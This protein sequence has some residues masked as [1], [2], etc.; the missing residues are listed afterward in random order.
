MRWSQRTL[1]KKEREKDGENGRKEQQATRLW[2]WYTL[3]SLNQGDHGVA[4][5]LN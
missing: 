5:K 2:F 4:E 3:G 1:P